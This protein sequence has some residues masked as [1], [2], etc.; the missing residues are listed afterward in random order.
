[1]AEPDGRLYLVSRL[2]FSESQI[3]TFLKVGPSASGS[4]VVHA[5][6]DESLLCHVLFEHTPLSAHA[7]APG[8]EHLL[9]AGSSILIHDDGI[10]PVGIKIGRLHHPGIELDAFGCGDGKQ[11]LGGEVIGLETLGHLLVVNQGGKQLSPIVVE[12]VDPRSMEIAPYIDVIFEVL[13]EDGIVGALL[14]REFGNL[15]GSI[16][17]V[18]VALG[19]P[20]QLCRTLIGGKIGIARG[21]VI[22]IDIGHHH[23]SLHHLS[24]QPSV[25][26]IEIELVE[27]VPLAGQQDMVVGNLDGREH[28]LPDIAVHL[29]A[30][31][32]LADGRERVDHIDGQLV[33]MAVHGIDG[34]LGGVAGHDDTGD[35]S[36]LV[37]GHLQLPGLSRLDVETVHGDGGVLFA[38]HRIFVAVE[39]GIF[40]VFLLGRAES[41][42][43]LEGKFLHLALVVP[44]PAY[45]PAVCCEDHTAVHRELFFVHP[46][47]NAV[48]DLV[49]HAILGH[50]ALGI[51][52]EQL[53]EEDVVVSDESNL[54]AV[55]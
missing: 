48:D 54:L 4:A 3:G 30:D 7:T 46:V 40:G 42:E 17:H 31:N 45:L 35:I 51:V 15:S 43:P 41:L 16:G 26:G 13:A 10:F 55:G 23:L 19:G 29:V 33:L 37:E 21:F 24:H 53:H 14:G 52:V 47:G 27:T 38:R 39:T 25:E 50:L 5:D 12:G 44:Y 2:Q 32:E 1:M 18:D 36:V 11:F 28:I 6:N 22:A 49:A 8:V 20:C 34:H 9:A